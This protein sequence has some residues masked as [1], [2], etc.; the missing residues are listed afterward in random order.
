MNKSNFIAIGMT[1]AASVA[2]MVVYNFAIEPV[3][4]KKLNRVDDSQTQKSQNDWQISHLF[5]N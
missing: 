5:G 1:V 2:A 3:I 4:N